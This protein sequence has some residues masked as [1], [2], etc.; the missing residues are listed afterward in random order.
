MINP[1]LISG[2]TYNLDVQGVQD[3]AGN[4]MVPFT[5]TFTVSSITSAPPV[6]SA[7]AALPFTNSILLTFSEP[8]DPATATDPANYFVGGF[9]PIMV[10]NV[11]QEQPR[12]VRLLISSLLMPGT[13]YFLGVHGVSDPSGN[14]MNPTTVNFTTANVQ[15]PCPGGTLLV[16]QA[17]SE[18]NSDGMWHVVEDDWYRCPDGTTRR[19][20]VS[21][22]KTTQ[23]CSNPN[24]SPVGLLYPTESDVASHCQSPVYQGQVII[25]ECVGGLWSASTYNLYQCLDGTYY[26]SGPVQNVP[27]T[28]AT[29]CSQR[30]PAP[31]P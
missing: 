24:P 20:R 26:V 4:L 12:C 5:F 8:V 9:S 15:N 23:P 30:P 10:Q 25:Y 3:L 1:P 21:D 28:P 16:R 13:N 29:G 31:T 27:V 18:C 14:V 19:F 22:V 11:I 17:Y 2:A 6:L 7:V